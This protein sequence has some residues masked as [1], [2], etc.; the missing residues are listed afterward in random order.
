VNP[1]QFTDIG[2]YGDGREAAGNRAELARHIEHLAASK[3]PADQTLEVEI[4]DVTLAGRL[5]SW[6]TGLHDVPRFASRGAW[7]FGSDVRVMR[8]ATWPSI[9]LRYRLTQG[10]QVVASGEE[11]V[12]DMSYLDWPNSY[13]SGD[14]LR[15]EKSM[16]DS[17]FHQRL[18]QHQ[19]PR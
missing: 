6:S 19:P 14:S 3:L 16:L 10:E 13:P 5:E 1:D 9:K 7:P 4:L 15:Y 12:S 11:S 2:R 18:V 8:S 17:W